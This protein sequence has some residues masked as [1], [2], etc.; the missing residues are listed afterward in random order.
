MYKMPIPLDEILKN[1]W[2]ANEKLSDNENRKEIILEKEGE[3]IFCV[4]WKHKGGDWY[5]VGLKTQVDGKFANVDFQLF[6]A[7]KKVIRRKKTRT[8]TFQMLYIFIITVLELF[9]MKTI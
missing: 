2:V 8:I 6:N 3:K 4:L 9:L 1:G 7:I 5:V